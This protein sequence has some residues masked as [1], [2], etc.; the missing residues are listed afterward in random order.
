MESKLMLPEGDIFLAAPDNMSADSVRDMC[1]WLSVVIR[2]VRRKHGMKS[3]GLSQAERIKEYLAASDA[4]QTV[5]EIENGTGIERTSVSAVLYRTH[6]TLF[7]AS[8][9]AGKR[10][11]CWAIAGEAA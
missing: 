2:S 9:I 5:T 8:K 1:N 10:G 3:E 7:V 4:P 11:K 6:P